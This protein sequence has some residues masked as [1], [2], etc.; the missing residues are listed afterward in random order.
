MSDQEAL[1][2]KIGKQ[3][4]LVLFDLLGRWLDDQNGKEISAQTVDDSEIWA[5][6][7]IYGSL[8]SILVE[9]FQDD[10]SNIVKSAREKVRAAN[11]GEWPL[12]S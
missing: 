5:L 2:I 3:E 10:Y 8:Q 11:G 4:A 12:A 6:N 1:S 7:G 9:P